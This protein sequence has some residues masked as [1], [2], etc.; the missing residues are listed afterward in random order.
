MILFFIRNLMCSSIRSVYN[1]IFSYEIWGSQAVLV[2][3]DAVYFGGY[4]FF[5]QTLCLRVPSNTFYAEEGG[6]SFCPEHWHVP[7]ELQ[8]AKSH[9]SLR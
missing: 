9:N 2:G 7:A 3:R 8:G 6:T 4:H 1:T 5:A